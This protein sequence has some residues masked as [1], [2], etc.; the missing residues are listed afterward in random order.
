MKRCQFY[1][2]PLI[3]A[4][5]LFKM[6]QNFAYEEGTCLLYSGNSYETAQ[7]SYLFL[8]PYECI[9]IHKG[10][11]QRTRMNQPSIQIAEANPWEAMQILGN[12]I[13]QDQKASA[14]PEWVGF[15]S[16][17]M[18]AFSDKDVVISHFSTPEAYWQKSAVTLMVDQIGKAFVEVII[19]EEMIF[20]HPCKE[21]IQRL[22]EKKA[23]NELINAS[24][25]SRVSHSSLILASISDTE[26]SYIKKIEWAKEFIKSGDVYQINLSQQWEFLGEKGSL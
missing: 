4:T 5:A 23:W 18:G 9:K 24:N 1:L 12:D 25:P 22:S 8:F 2:D 20:H 15:F 6:A 19:D 17:E 16:Y 21:W 7:K 11:Q 3:D 13:G 10:I 14:F 26:E